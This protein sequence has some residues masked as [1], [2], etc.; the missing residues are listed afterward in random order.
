V[1]GRVRSGICD[2]LQSGRTGST[3]N[4]HQL[5]VMAAADTPVEYP[6]A[7]DLVKQ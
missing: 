1:R 6:V 4:L 3:V 7:I 5:N 2:W